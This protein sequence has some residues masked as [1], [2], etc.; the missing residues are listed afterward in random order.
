[1]KR[2]ERSGIDGKMNKDKGG[3]NGKWRRK[4][5]RQEIQ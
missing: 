3:K 2:S 4:Q 1:M 5:K